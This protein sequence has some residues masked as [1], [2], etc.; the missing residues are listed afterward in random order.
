MA[1]Q[2]LAAVGTLMPTLLH[3]AAVQYTAVGRRV[4]LLKWL[5]LFGLQRQDYEA[6]AEVFDVALEEYKLRA[7]SHFLSLI[8]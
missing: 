2:L 6:V 8:L 7:I 4:E 1:R 5:L 3:A